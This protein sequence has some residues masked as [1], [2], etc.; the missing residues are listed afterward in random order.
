MLFI[1]QFVFGIIKNASN[2]TMI[3]L[4]E[5]FFI[6]FDNYFLVTKGL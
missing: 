2:R 5:A 6:K 1:K 3:I 4:F